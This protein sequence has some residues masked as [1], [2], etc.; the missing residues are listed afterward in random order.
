MR[1]RNVRVGWGK[2]VVLFDRVKVE[3]EEKKEG[4]AESVDI[5]FFNRKSPFAA[6]YFEMKYERA[7]LTKE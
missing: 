1:K 3:K 6:S 7:C 2:G 4:A 5:Y